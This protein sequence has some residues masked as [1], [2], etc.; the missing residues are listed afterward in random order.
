[1]CHTYVWD[2]TD[3]HLLTGLSG[4]TTHQSIEHLLRLD[5][6]RIEKVLRELYSSVLLAR[7]IRQ[8]A[9]K[10]SRI[11]RYIYFHFADFCGIS[12]RHTYLSFPCISEF[13]KRRAAV[14]ASLLTAGSSSEL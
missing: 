13:K 12:F 14:A 2:E 10:E 3:V 4:E 5:H 7:I 9:T 1:M 6:A 8:T 11:F